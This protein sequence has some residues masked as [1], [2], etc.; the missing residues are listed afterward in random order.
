MTVEI[1]ST[2][3]NAVSIPK[4]KRVRPRRAVQKF[5]PV[6]DSA[7][8]G[9]A[10]KA[11]ALELFFEAT[12]DPSHLRYPTIEKT[13]KPAKKLSKQFPNEIANT[14]RIIGLLR[15]L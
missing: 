10:T 5:E 3:E 12:G 4:V 1:A 2:R 11:R 15:L 7:A 9:Y 6:I 8:A 14:S 13:A